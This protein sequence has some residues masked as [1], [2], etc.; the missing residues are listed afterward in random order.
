MDSPGFQRN[1]KFMTSEEEGGIEEGRVFRKRKSER[2]GR[3]RNQ[4]Y[5]VKKNK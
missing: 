3:T 2:L 1:N 5:D 4:F